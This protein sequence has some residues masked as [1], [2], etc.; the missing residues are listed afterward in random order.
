LYE[1]AGVFARCTMQALP[2][3]HGDFVSK[4]VGLAE[5]AFQEGSKSKLQLSDRSNA[6]LARFALAGDSSV[7]VQSAISMLHVDADASTMQLA[8]A[9]LYSPNAVATLQA[10]VEAAKQREVQRRV[11]LQKPNQGPLAGYIAD[12]FWDIG[13][14]ATYLNEL[15][16]VMGHP[17]VANKAEFQQ[18]MEGDVN[19]IKFVLHALDWLLNCNDGDCDSIPYALTQKIVDTII[20][21][22]ARNAI[23]EKRK[24]ARE[25]STPK[26]PPSSPAD[27]DDSDE[28]EVFTPGSLANIPAPP[29]NQ[30][31]A[32]YALTRGICGHRG[33]HEA[34]CSTRD[35]SNVDDELPYHTPKDIAYTI[36]V[37][38]T[39]DR[40]SDDVN[41]RP[42]PPFT[43][44]CFNAVVQHF[45]DDFAIDEPDTNSR[46]ALT[47]AREVRWHPSGEYAESFASA[48]ALEH[49][50]ARGKRLAGKVS[51]PLERAMILGVVAALKI[52]QLPHMHWV[53]VAVEDGAVPTHSDR[54]VTRPVGR[55]RGA[56]M[57]ASDAGHHPL[58]EIQADTTGRGGWTQ[59]MVEVN[60]R[61]KRKA[62]G[63]NTT[64]NTFIAPS[65]EDTGYIAAP[66]IATGSVDST[67]RMESLE[68]ALDD[69]N[70]FSE[71]LKKIVEFG[72]Y[73]FAIP[74][75]HAYSKEKELAEQAAAVG[76]PEE[77]RKALWNDF[78]RYLAVAND[79]II[80][81]IRTL[82]GLIGED[83]DSLLVSADSATSESAKELAT[84]KRKIAEK[85]ADFQSKVLETFMAGIIK[86]SGLK[87]KVGG[88]GADPSGSSESEDPLV[89]VDKNTEKE[90]SDLASGQSGRP[91]FEA[92]IALRSLCQE[93]KG[94]NKHLSD[95]M[96]TLGSI[97]STLAQQ[98]T[99]GSDNVGV[100][101]MSIA[102]LATPRNSY[103]VRLRDDTTAAIRTAY[104]RL[105]GEMR[106]NCGHS[107]TISL[108]ELIEGADPTLSL[109]FA[110]FVGHCLVSARTSTGVSALY[111]SGSQI[112]VNSAQAQVSIRRLCTYASSYAARTP[113]PNFSDRGGRAAYFAAAPGDGCGAHINHR[114]MHRRELIDYSG[115]VGG[116]AY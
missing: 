85:V 94:Q 82:S 45:G 1:V 58:P 91:F 49:A 8:P 86:E 31:F 26:A 27:S 15:A 89:V 80:V 5:N 3:S 99:A 111:A 84:Q 88:G 57:L 44:Q 96:R 62:A 14:V 64:L 35:G 114:V 77:Q 7:Y 29:T 112:L 46:I 95:V 10:A 104:D 6:Q 52:R 24:A 12:S 101:G 17:Q 59:D 54:L 65:V 109:R 38:N 76:S 9:S 34:D 113:A 33:P 70:Y 18:K 67:A 116:G 90:L 78:C 20:V 48:A 40:S 23:N 50:V 110:E 74:S 69:G 41:V 47:P 60:R 115:W 13:G 103:F 55:F 68:E 83:A 102:E 22:D 11:S 92:N 32:R 56:M 19:Y 106:I 98:L 21:Q 72:L 30:V 93:T 39:L 105:C 66:T 97:T 51:A 73:F 81:F 107:R 100:I 42:D 2:S 28:T 108:F 43:K 16:A 53:S 36:R 79:K 87:L 37:A 4:V 25:S 75:P 61:S 63:D 71:R